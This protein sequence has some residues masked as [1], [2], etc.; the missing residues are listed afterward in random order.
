MQAGG[1]A[2]VCLQPNVLIHSEIGKASFLVAE[3]ISNVSEIS[4]EFG[5]RSLAKKSTAKAVLK[6]HNKW[7]VQHGYHT[8]EHLG[9]SLSTTLHLKI[10]S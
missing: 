8:N 1:Y 3:S 7:L 9:R 4:G 2:D 6:V 10:I 5:F